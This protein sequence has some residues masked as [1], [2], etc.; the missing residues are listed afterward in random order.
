MTNRAGKATYAYGLLFQSEAIKKWH[1]S[2][3]DSFKQYRS[4]WY[5]RVDDCDYGAAPLN[6]NIEVTSRCNMACTFCYNIKMPEDQI[7][8]MDISTYQKFINDGVKEGLVAVNLNGLGEPTLRADLPEMIAYAKEKGVLEVMFHTNGSI[9]SIELAEKL[10]K[11]GLDKII[12]SVDSPE[13]ESYEKMRLL[14]TYDADSKLRIKPMDFDKIRQ[15]VETFFEVR[16]RAGS[17][18]PFIRTTMVLT[19]E[20]E[21]YVPLFIE[22]WKDLADEISVQDMLSESK[23][24]EK[25]SWRNSNKSRVFANKRQLLEQALQK[26]IKYVCPLLYQSMYFYHNG[27]V[28]MCS[29]PQARDIKIIGNIKSSTVAEIWKSSEIVDLRRLHEEGKWHEVEMCR[30]CDMPYVEIAS[31]LNMSH[32]SQFSESNG[33]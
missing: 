20:N 18:K 30:N 3:P 10:I 26:N 13:K 9:M 23:I 32:T 16:K 21:K 25:V 11:A 19:D 5:D 17:V 7:G 24:T 29:Y 28:A 31:N 14:K 1:L 15:N 22:R 6:A 8:D 2:A 12:F 4:S 33:H 27:D